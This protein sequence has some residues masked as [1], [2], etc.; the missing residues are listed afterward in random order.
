MQQHLILKNVTTI[1]CVFVCTFYRFIYCQMSRN[2]Q[3]NLLHFIFIWHEW[4]A[5]D[6]NNKNFFEIIIYF[7]SQAIWIEDD[8]H[9]AHRKKQ[10]VWTM[11]LY[12]SEFKIKIMESNIRCWFK[13]SL[14]DLKLSCDFCTQNN[15]VWMKSDYD[16]VCKTF[17]VWLLY[18]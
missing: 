8:K 15:C 3:S 6:V 5:I 12:I 14:N 17:Y 4:F 2:V 16:F 1:E 7:H 10:C 18:L 11:N 13:C 9:F